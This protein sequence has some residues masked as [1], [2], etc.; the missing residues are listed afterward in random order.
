MPWQVCHGQ[1]A[2]L[3]FASPQGIYGLKRWLQHMAR[4][5][6]TDIRKSSTIGDFDL[7]T[8]VILDAQEP[9]E[10]CILM[11]AKKSC[12]GLLILESSIAD[13][14]FPDIGVRRGDQFLRMWSNPDHGLTVGEEL[15]F[16]G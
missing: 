2:P 10:Q 8:A 13:K 16:E 4:L 3:P 1:G 11:L 14:E 7:L 12:K 15:R 5:I 9:S 6:I